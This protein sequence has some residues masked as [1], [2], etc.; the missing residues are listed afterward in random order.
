MRRF[1]LVI[2]ALFFCI[3]N[4]AQTIKGKIKASNGNPVEAAVKSKGACEI[5]N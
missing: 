4:Y 5:K 3:F 2:C 1:L